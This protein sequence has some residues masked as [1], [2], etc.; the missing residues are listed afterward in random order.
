[1]ANVLLIEPDAVLSRTYMQALQHAG[2]A[3]ACA[4]DAQGA[5]SAADETQPD[6]VILELQLAT[7]NGIEFLHEFRSYPE[8]QQVPVLVNTNI[9]PTTMAASQEALE[10]DLGVVQ[11]LYK[12]RTSLEQLL[13]AVKQQVSPA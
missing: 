7:H 6:I 3:V 10:R 2:H 9:T 13:R 4:H 5:I 11:C 1:M 8:W 12:P